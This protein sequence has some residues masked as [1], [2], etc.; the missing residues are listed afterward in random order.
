MVEARN[1]EFHFGF[2]AKPFVPRVSSSAVSTLKV[3]IVLY[4]STK[5]LD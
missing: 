4:S 1:H 2:D 3:S 5:S